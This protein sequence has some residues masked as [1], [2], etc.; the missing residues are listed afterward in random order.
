[1]QEDKLYNNLVILLKLFKNKP[2]QLAKYM[3]ENDAFKDIFLEKIINS[4]K[5][6]EIDNKIKGHDVVE[7]KEHFN[8]VTEMKKY[9]QELLQPIVFKDKE[10]N[11]ENLQK[12]LNL[13]L[14][15]ALSKE[16]YEGAV[17]IR[18]YM[19]MLN[20]EPKPLDI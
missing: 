9:Q 17:R 11:F 14:L 1:M 13:Q 18:D 15:E 16:D 7:E 3:L 19:L 2:Y 8:N 4:K 5:I 20:I 10:D 6:N 12:K